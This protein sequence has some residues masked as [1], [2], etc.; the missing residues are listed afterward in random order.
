MEKHKVEIKRQIQESVPKYIMDS[1]A[2]CRRTGSVNR[3]HMRGEER[4][5]QHEKMTANIMRRGQKWKNLD[6]K[7]RGASRGME[8]DKS[9]EGETEEK[10]YRGKH[11]T[12]DRRGCERWRLHPST[13]TCLACEKEEAL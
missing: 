6:E 4:E 1:R 10:I 5:Q 11:L 13:S 7:H 12:Y 8:E 2:A 3:I 9:R